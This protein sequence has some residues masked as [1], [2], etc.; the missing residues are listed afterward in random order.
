MPDLPFA[1]DPELLAGRHLGVNFGLAWTGVRDILHHAAAWK[2]GSSLGSSWSTSLYWTRGPGS[3][4][5][6]GSTSAPAKFES[7]DESQVRKRRGV[8]P[9]GCIQG[10]GKGEHIS[11]RQGTPLAFLQL[12]VVYEAAV[13]TAVLVVMHT[14]LCSRCEPN[15]EAKKHRRFPRLELGGAA[16]AAMQNAV[17]PA[18]LLT[19]ATS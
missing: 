13:R 7:Q 15:T 6:L 19:Q 1:S 3:T 9:G 8:H 11:V 14:R 12:P 5:S 10:L 4:P 18:D 17:C 16:S 2:P